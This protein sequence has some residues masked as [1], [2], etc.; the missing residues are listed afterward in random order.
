LEKILLELA[1]RPLL[2]NS[3]NAY[4]DAVNSFCN[5][6]GIFSHGFSHFQKI[7]KE[8]TQKTD[9]LESDVSKRVDST[10]F[11]V[12]VKKTKKKLRDEV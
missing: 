10:F 12:K 2:E 1:G 9:K 11:K 8:L 3:G 5:R 7:S 4:N 6:L